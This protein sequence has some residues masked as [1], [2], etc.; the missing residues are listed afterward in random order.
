MTGL[1]KSI[2][3][4]LATATCVQSADTRH[5]QLCYAGGCCLKCLAQLTPGTQAADCCSAAWFTPATL[6]D[7]CAYAR[8]NLV[9][10]TGGFES[11]SCCTVRSAHHVCTT[12]ATS[13]CWRLGAS[14]T[15]SQQRFLGAASV[16]TANAACST[17]DQAQLVGRIRPEHGGFSEERIN[18]C[19]AAFFYKNTCMRQTGHTDGA[20]TLL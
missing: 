4:A 1:S 14:T 19:A 6:L 11:T 18:E 12:R 7:L 16:D 13:I 17:F 8:Y 10:T 5:S 15:V 9:C 2:P 20:R 3:P